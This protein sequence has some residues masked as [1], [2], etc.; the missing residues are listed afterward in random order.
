MVGDSFTLDIVVDASSQPVDTVGAYLNF[1]PTMLQCA[2]AT[3]TP[4]TKLT[5]V[6][7]NQCNNSGTIDFSAAILG[8]A[9]VTE[10]FTL[11]TINLQALTTPGTTT[12]HFVQVTGRYTR[13]VYRSQDVTGDLSDGVVVLQELTPT[14]TSTP[15]STPTLTP[16]PTPTPSPSAAIL[17]LSPVTH[18][19]PVGNCVEMTVN[20][21]TH[22]NWVNVVDLVLQFNPTYFQVVQSDCSTAATQ[23]NPSTTL[24]LVLQN[25]VNNP[26]GEIRFGAGHNLTDPPVSGDFVVA[27]FTLKGIGATPPGG[28]AIAF[29]I[30]T[31]VYFSGSPIPLVTQDATI[32]VT[33]VTTSNLVGQVTL[34]GR[35]TPPSPSWAGYPL[36]LRMLPVP[37]GGPVVPVTTTTTLDAAGVFTVT[38]LVAAIY[39][40][41]VK[42]PHSLTNYRQNVDLLSSFPATPIPFGLLREG[43]A[44]DDD[45]VLGADFSILATAYGR[46]NGDP[47]FDARADFDGDGCVAGAD[48]SLLLTNYGQ[49]GPILIPLALPTGVGPVVISLEPARRQV[50]LGEVVPVTVW[51]RAGGQRVDGVD[52]VFRFDPRRLQVVD[53]AGRPVTGVEAGNALPLVLMNQ[54]DHAAGRVFYSAGRA[55]SGEAPGGEFVVATFYVKVVAGDAPTVA[56]LSAGD[57]VGAYYRGESVLDRMEGVTLTVSPGRPGPR[58]WLPTIMH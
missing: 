27:T 3:L 42:N 54:V 46:C 9:A 10:T 17:S 40:V 25:S 11:A 36:R 28:S 43:D 21:D 31:T 35:G 19:M 52:T 20:L 15:T 13:A 48:F 5:T 1:D 33:P 34:Q 50:G 7:V 12:L 57:L 30:G 38:G 58:L 41:Y 8:G 55:L 18:T 37:D 45:R 47:G 26:A 22:G 51:V 4:G 24:P 39:D 56:V 44:N 23:I 6:A 29:A 32:Q 14:P 2:A 49:S 16:T 53:A